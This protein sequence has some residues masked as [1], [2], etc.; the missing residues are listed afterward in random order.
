MVRPLVAYSTIAWHRQAW[1]KTKQKT[2]K[3][4]NKKARKESK[5]KKRQREKVC[6]VFLRWDPKKRMTPDEAVRHE[7]LLSSSFSHASSSSSS[8]TMTSST[9]NANNGNNGNNSN[10][11]AATVVE[12]SQSSHAQTVTRLTVSEALQLPS[13][14][15]Y[16]PYSLLALYLKHDKHMKRVGT[17][18][19]SKSGGA[20]TTDNSKSSSSLVVKSKLN[21]S[22]SSHALASSAQTTTSRHASTGD[23]VSS[24]DPNLDDSGTFLPPILWS[25]VY[26]SHF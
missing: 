23:I 21:G 2:N 12:T 11:T 15:E 22:A 19:N 9:V 1:K 4:T 6:F 25:R 10:A 24:L 26:A 20:A 17:S 14:M 16:A 13:N 5:K 7:W 18:E 3:Q 8:S